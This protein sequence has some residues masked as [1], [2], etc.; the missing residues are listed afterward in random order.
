MRTLLLLS[1]L[2]LGPA[3]CGSNP[4][5]G[6][7]GDALPE[8]GARDGA[9]P[10]DRPAPTPD[11]DPK[12]CRAIDTC[13]YGCST[14][15][16][17]CIDACLA[18]ASTDEKAKLLAMNACQ[19]TQIKGNCS[20]SCAYLDLKCGLCMDPPCAKEIA[21]CF[22]VALGGT[23][24]KICADAH[25]CLAACKPADT[26]C[27]KNCFYAATAD[28]QAQLVALEAC[29]RTALL[30]SC[31]GSCSDPAS[32]TCLDCINK[33]CAAESKACFGK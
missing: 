27:V 33:A 17:A 32:T 22:G 18:P 11:L 2:A 24:S 15:D 19:E 5:T 16:K 8:R 13:L 21:A 28:A 7:L 31:K 23:G 25:A 26:L 30:G 1:L 29:N 10:S 12:T 3:A 6:P 14:T 9:T 20:R 4:T